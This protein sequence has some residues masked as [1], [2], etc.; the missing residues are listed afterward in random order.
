MALTAAGQLGIGT[1]QP[2]SGYNL[3]VIGNARVQGHIHLDASDANLNSADLQ[4][5][6]KTQ[7]YVSF[8]EAGSTNDF[9]YLRQ[10]G[11]SDAIK[12]ALDFHNDANDAGFI[13]RDVNSVGGGGDTVTD[14]FELKRGG[15]MYM[16]GK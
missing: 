4:A 3:D 7:T 11:G 5:T 16:S 1:T 6:N 12:L 9:A 8:G 13:I 15:D 2:T 10:I 14:R